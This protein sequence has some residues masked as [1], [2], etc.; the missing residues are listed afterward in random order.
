MYRELF[1]CFTQEANIALIPRLREIARCERLSYTTAILVLM[2][3]VTIAAATADRCDISHIQT[4]IRS[5]HLEKVKRSD[6]RSIDDV[7]PIDERIEARSSR[8]MLPLL[9][10]SRYL[11]LSGYLTTKEC[12]GESRFADSALADEYRDLVRQ[13]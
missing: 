9:I 2:E 6:P 12:V 11:T 8:R 13:V 7:S 1:F 3:T 10:D 4:D 5:I